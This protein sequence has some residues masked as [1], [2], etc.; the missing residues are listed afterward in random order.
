MSEPTLAIDAS[1]AARLHAKPRAVHDDF[2]FRETSRRMAE[3]LV[4]VRIDP[5]R[6]LDLGC[7]SGADRAYLGERFPGAAYCGVDRSLARLRLAA[8]TPTGPAWS[9]WL[10]RSRRSAFVQADF[11]SLPFAARSVDCLWSNL[12]IHW[13]PT[14]H[15]VIAEWSR[16][17]DV[18]GLVAFSS[19]GP[20]TLREVTEA[21][22][23]V[24]RD[25]HVLPFTDLHDFGDMLVA[26]GFTTPVIDAERIAL[27]YAD[28]DALWR[29]VRS[30][31][32]NAASGRVL[33]LR[34]RAFREAVHEALASLRGPDG[35]YRLTLELVFAHAWKGEPR[36]SSTG[37]AIVRMP[38]SR[39]G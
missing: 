21:F 11:A 5:A 16:V 33:S 31:G 14:P 38:S 35:R 12:A 26:S 20:D 19:F 29:D 32:G 18:G 36:T 39:R 17:T 7:G 25:D 22:R 28:Q 10:G 30:L 3:R 24:D 4:T 8:G 2:I 13:S 34:G 27:T 15:R 6:V 23:L 37:D 9:R 1:R